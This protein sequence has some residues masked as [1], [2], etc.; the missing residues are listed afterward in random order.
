MFKRDLLLRL[1]ANVILW[2]IPKYLAF[3]AKFMF[4]LFCRYP[5]LKEIVYPAGNIDIYL[6][7]DY[8]II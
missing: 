7:N 3:N 6:A 1:R 2:P 8:H 5:K 4:L